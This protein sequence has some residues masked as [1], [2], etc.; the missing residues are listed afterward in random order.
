MTAAPDPAE[1]IAPSDPALYARRRPLL[2]VG[3]WAMV[4]LCAVCVAAGA[5][6]A[7]FGPTWFPLTRKAAQ[8]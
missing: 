2:G 6:V 4:V 1:I 3:F 7:R 5:M 8:V